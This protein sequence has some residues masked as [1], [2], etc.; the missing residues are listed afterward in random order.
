MM[1]TNIPLLAL[2]LATASPLLAPA[3]QA[4]VN[5][6][7]LPKG[8]VVDIDGNTYPTILFGD[9]WWMAENLRVFRFADGTPLTYYKDTEHTDYMLQ[10]DTEFST[11]GST[12]DGLSVENHYAYP[13]RTLRYVHTYGLLYPYYAAIN[14]HGLCPQ[15]WTFPDTAD[16]FSLAR[17]VVGPEAFE[18]QSDGY[19]LIHGIGKFF[20]TDNGDLWTPC[21]TIGEVTGEAG[22]HIVPAGRLHVSG[23]NSFG[24]KAF[25]WTPNYVHADGSGNG[26]RLILF[27]YTDNDMKI[28]NF[29]ANSPVCIRCIRK[30]T[31]Q[32]MA[33]SSVQQTD[34]NPIVLPDYHTG[35]LRILNLPPGITWRLFSILGTLVAQGHSGSG[36]ELSILLPPLPPGIYT[37]ATP[38]ATVK[39]IYR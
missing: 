17:Y 5:F 11:G 29:R 7:E 37:L 32:E 4:K 36:G 10:Y 28:T 39:W 8:R 33:I 9:T 14:P 3:Q 15:G 16:W 12:Y 21:D 26:R 35:R 18:D 34:D 31:A 38:K 6:A 27:D 23:Y 24:E 22:M 30:A 2:L 19:F 13:M 1:Q 25:F 20:K